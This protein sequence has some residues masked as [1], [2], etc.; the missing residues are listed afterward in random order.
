MGKDAPDEASLIM[1]FH[2]IGCVYESDLRKPILREALI[3]KNAVQLHDRISLLEHFIL[4]NKDKA[5]ETLYD[6][7]L[8]NYIFIPKEVQNG[9]KV[10]RQ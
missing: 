2:I 4:K 1:L 3:L 7:D 5:G 10:S 6:S 9:E 8:G